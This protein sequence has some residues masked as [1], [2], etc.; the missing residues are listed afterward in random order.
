MSQKL[1]QEAVMIKY[2]KLTEAVM[3]KNPKLAKLLEGCTARGI[4]PLIPK[5]TTPDWHLHLREGHGVLRS[6]N[7][8]GSKLCQE[9]T[10]SNLIKKKS[11][12]ISGNASKKIA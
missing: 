11:I 2:P 10:T 4:S 3:I 7:Q 8:D 5:E 9:T 6:I 12:L 1:P